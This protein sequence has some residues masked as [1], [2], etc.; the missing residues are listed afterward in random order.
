M[1]DEIK[2]FVGLLVGNVYIVVGILVG[3]FFYAVLIYSSVG[4]LKDRLKKK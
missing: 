1:L 4:W 3:L 2:S